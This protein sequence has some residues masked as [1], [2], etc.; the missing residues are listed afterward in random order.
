MLYGHNASDLPLEEIKYDR[1]KPLWWF[2]LSTDM[3]KNRQKM[4]LTW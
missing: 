2:L 4:K 3:E 1:K